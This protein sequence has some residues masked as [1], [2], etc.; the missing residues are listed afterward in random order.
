MQKSLYILLLSVVILSFIAVIHHSTPYQ[1]NS[2]PSQQT[3]QATT[4]AETAVSAQAQTSQT[5]EADNNIQPAIVLTGALQKGESFSEALQR[6]LLHDKQADELAE[7]ITQKLSRVVNLR[8]SRPGEAFALVMDYSGKLIRCTYEKNPF[9]IYTMEPDE[10]ENNLTIAKEDITLERHVVKLSGAIDGSLFQAFARLGESERLTLAFA[11]IFASRI[12]FNNDLTRGDRFE[13]LL[14][15]YYKNG[16]FVGYGRIL[17]AKL[18]GA[19]GKH[20]AFYF[21]PSD[22]PKGNYYDETGKTLGTAF[23]KSPLPI[24]K[25]TSGFT[26]HRNHPVLGGDRPHQGID[27]AAPVGTPVMAVADGIVSFAGWK[28]GYGNTLSIK[29]PGGYETQY[30]HL[31]RFA[32]GIKV[33]VHVAQKQVVARVGMTGIATG[34]HLDY[35]IAENGVLKNPLSVKF[36]SVFA[37]SGHELNQFHAQQLHLAQLMETP[38]PQK[39]VLVET[40]TTKGPPDGWNG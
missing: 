1:Q 34:P 16:Q 32:D 15:K 17:S 23:L 37:L 31:S 9:E 5:Q 38:E 11:D 19:K 36:R 29:H 24:F 20:H 12:D 27:L 2:V 6:V 33:G 28:N 10:D 3:V 39:L 14:E 8:K 22:A 30:A 18:E 7:K 25:V 13:M 4:P 21:K 26:M 40:L 35:R